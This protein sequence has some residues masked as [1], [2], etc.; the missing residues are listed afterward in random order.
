M[1][2]RRTI[3]LILP[4]A[5]SLPILMAVLVILAQA[6]HPVL[7]DSN[8]LYVAPGG[9][10]GGAGLCYDT[11]QAAVDD[12]VDGD[13]IKVAGGVYT[14]TDSQVVYINK[15]ITL[16]GGYSI[17]DWANAYTLALPTVIDA[18]NVAGRRGVYIDGTGVPRITLA[19]LS[20]QRGKANT[21][22]GGGLYIE[23]GTVILTD[24]VFQENDAPNQNGGAVAI[25][26]GMVTLDKNLMIANT[27]DQGGGAIYIENSAGTVTVR[28]NTFIRNTALEG[29]GLYVNDGTADI[30]SNNFQSNTAAY[31]GAAFFS[32][33]TVIALGN[34]FTQNHA[35]SGGAVS[36][37]NTWLGS[38]SLIRN[39]I[40]DNSVTNFGGGLFI[41]QSEVTLNG[42]TII[43]NTADTSGGGIAIVQSSVSGQNDVIAANTSSEGVHS[44]DSSVYADHWSLAENGGYALWISSGAAAFTNTIVASHAIAG[45]WGDR[46]ANLTADH[47]LFFNSGTPCGGGAVCTNSMTGDPKFIDAAKGDCHIGPDSAAINAGIAAGVRID[48]DNQPRFGE[49][50]LGAD[51]FWAPGAPY[52]AYLPLLLR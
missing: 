35:E 16:T 34:T 21:S 27:A 18:E 30:T 3:L 14:S 15:A 13:S 39:T 40:A 49:P 22:N 2:N 32:R 17:P 12:A 9:D 51:E 45:L 10:C 33:G 5:F 6:H 44:S 47:T 48:F 28:R 52:L 50:D 31:G 41:Y 4:V 46:G 23:N 29:G 1:I 37:H 24:N 38:V 20:I 42:N 36:I 8:T 43:S 7:V 26:S 19:G 25:L 11:I